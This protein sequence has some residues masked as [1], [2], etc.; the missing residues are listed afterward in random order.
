TTRSAA[1]G[2]YSFS[3]LPSGPY[4]VAVANVPTGQNPSL[5][6]VVPTTGA[7]AADI[8]IHP[9]ADLLAT[10]FHVAPTPGATSINWG[11]DVVVTYT[12]TN[13]RLGEAGP[14]HA[15]IRLSGNGVIDAA[16]MLLATVDVGA[17][18]AGHSVSASLTVH[19][20]GTPP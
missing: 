2:T 20:P 7:T 14:S 4:E 10:S 12:I 6:V 16:A 13:R 5:A 15:E 11:D 9:N 18:A 1:N 8:G 19:L 17:L 3:D